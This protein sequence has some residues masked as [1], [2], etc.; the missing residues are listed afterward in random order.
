MISIIICLSSGSRGDSS[1]QP[2]AN[3]SASTTAR[4]GRPTCRQ[5]IVD[6]FREVE[7]PKEVGT[8]PQTKQHYSWFHG[9][10]EIHKIMFVYSLRRNIMCG[11]FSG[12]RYDIAGSRRRAAWGERG[13][14]ILGSSERANIWLCDLVSRRSK[15]QTLPHQRTRRQVPV[16]RK[17]PS[18]TRNSARPHRVP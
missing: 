14:F 3:Q 2:S 9:L 8:D 18:S 13:W 5:A 12:G 7:I 1:A 4:V 15:M 11:T 17:Q 6:W 16:L 10:L